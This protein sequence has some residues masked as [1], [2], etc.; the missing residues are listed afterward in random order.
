MGSFHSV[1]YVG[2]TNCRACGKAYDDHS[3]LEA[4]ACEQVERDRIALESCPT[5]GI[6]FGKHSAEE[7]RACAHKQRDQGEK[8]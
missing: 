8:R 3:P 7:I 5:C 1:R 6:A 2:Q 4:L